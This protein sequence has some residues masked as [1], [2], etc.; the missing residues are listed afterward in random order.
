MF[1]LGR[2][3][4]YP[5]DAL[6]HEVASLLLE[7]SDAR[8]RLTEGLYVSEDPQDITGRLEY[9]LQKVLAAEPIERKLGKARTVQPPIVDYQTGLDDL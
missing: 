4:R 6:G 2:R 5:N 3:F 9:A 8:D 7:P 1:P